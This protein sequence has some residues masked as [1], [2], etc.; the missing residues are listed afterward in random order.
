LGN[1][2][3]YGSLAGGN[4][5]EDLKN[6]DILSYLNLAVDNAGLS[7][8]PL[9]YKD[10]NNPQPSSYESL[11]PRE[12][13]NFKNTRNVDTKPTSNNEQYGLDDM[14]IK[15]FHNPE[16]KWYGIRRKNYCR[17]L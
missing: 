17:F 14:D 16:K 11:S 1:D 9:S 10:T 6:N 3:D 4:M 5:A 13:N 15:Y 2:V 12:L 7:A 8:S